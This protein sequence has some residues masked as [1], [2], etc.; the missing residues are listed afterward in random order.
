MP[1]I[2]Y[3]ENFIDD[4]DRVYEFLY[5]KNSLAAQ[6][7]A[8]IL[9]EKLTLLASIPEAFTFLGDYRVYFLTFGSSGYA[10]LYDYDETADSIVLLRIKHQK[11]AGF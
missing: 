8:L 4:F 9:E 6:K 5:E 10:I 3:T 1:Q 7:L 2:I 11:E